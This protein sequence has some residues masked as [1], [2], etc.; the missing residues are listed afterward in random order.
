MANK[1]SY[2]K[3]PQ[4]GHVYGEEILVPEVR[5]C[6][7]SLVKP[8]DPPPPKPGMPE[9]SPRY[10]LTF[11]LPDNKEANKFIA[12]IEK[13][14]KEM[15][16]LYNEDKKATLGTITT[17]SDGNKFDLEKY[18]YYEGHKILVARNQKMP[19]IVDAKRQA[20]SADI[21]T[22]GCFVQALITPLITAHGVSYKLNAVQFRRDDGTKFGGSARDL[23]SMFSSVE[24]SDGAAPFE[25]DE[26]TEP[27][28]AKKKAVN[29]L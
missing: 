29:I 18:P 5:C 22:G 23:T 6:W 26:P 14:T 10:E 19:I 2:Y 16:A 9:G 25:A 20:G 8:K 4:F 24:S 27:V 11:L 1:K 15:L 21:I 17:Y 7:P 3:H 13:M 28:S 12:D